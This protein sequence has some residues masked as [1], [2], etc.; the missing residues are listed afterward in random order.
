MRD[1]VGLKKE[2]LERRKKGLAGD[3]GDLNHGRVGT[4]NKMAVILLKKE[5]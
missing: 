3:M 5:Q 4:R 2:D 1:A